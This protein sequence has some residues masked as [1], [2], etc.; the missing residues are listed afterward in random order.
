[1]RYLIRYIKQDLRKKMVFLSGPRQTGKTT[2]AKALVK[3][4]TYLNWDVREDKRTIKNIAWP[5]DTELVILDEL[6]KMPRWKNHLKGIVDKYHNTPALV[7][8]GSARLETFRKAGDPLTGRFFAYRL[9]PIDINEAADFTPQLSTDQ[10]LKRLL[11]TGGFPEA[12]IHETDAER[13]RNNRFDTVL[14]EDLRDVSNTGALRSIEIL[15]ELLRERVGATLSYASLAEDLSVSAPTVKS[16]IELLERLY[17]IFVVRPYAKGLVRAYRKEPKVYFYD[18]AAAY[19]PDVKGARFENLVATTLLK[20]CQWAHDVKGFK[21]ELCY[22]RD[23]DKREV[24]FVVL[25]NRSPFL[26]LEAKHSDD[27]IHPP[28]RYLTQRLSPQLSIQL[29]NNLEHPREQ[30]GI[31]IVSASHWLDTLHLN[32]AG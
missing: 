20:Y 18:C 32:W 21:L 14:R 25:K 11:V 2:L 23:R 28:L 22:F 12:Y 16:W 3:N 26:F 6:H 19:E 17:I 30:H 10:R 9:H 29:V 31:K 4:P 5:K 13:L 7:V 27:S 8:T 24:D 1:M 15:I